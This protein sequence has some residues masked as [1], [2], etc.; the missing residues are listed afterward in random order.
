MADPFNL[1]A[2]FY[3]Q[4]IPQQVAQDQANQ[5]GITTNQLYALYA[6]NAAQQSGGA[7]GLNIAGLVA[8]YQSGPG[9]FLDQANTYRTMSSVL[10]G[11]NQGQQ[12]TPTQPGTI[13]L[14]GADNPAYNTSLIGAKALDA[15]GLGTGTMTINPTPGMTPMGSKSGVAPVSSPTT[16]DIRGMPMPQTSVPSIF[17]PSRMPG[18]PT[19]ATASKIPG[20]ISDIPAWQSWFGKNVGNTIMVNGMPRTLA[21]GSEQNPVSNAITPGPLYDAFS[22]GQASWTANTPAQYAQAK[23]P[24]EAL[25]VTPTI[26]ANAAQTQTPQPFATPPT[27]PTTLPPAAPTSAYPSQRQ[28]WLGDIM[29]SEPSTQEINRTA[30]NAANAT[31]GNWMQGPAPTG[32]GQTQNLGHLGPTNMQLNAG[33]GLINQ[34]GQ[35]GAPLQRYAQQG[36][37]P[38]L[39]SSIPSPDDYRQLRPIA[40]S[41]AQMGFPGT[42]GGFLPRAAP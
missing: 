35:A 9:S 3:Q 7:Q 12:N 40:L 33:L 31:V 32:P 14:S 4:Q 22:K 6:A 1:N 42:P 18:T 34:A 21:T 41:G 37:M 38:W 19:A 30:A 39:Q 8:P 28:G 2:A 26:P 5:L 24:T 13:Q 23:P 27:I 10:G 36:P 17:S 25:K 20:G 16:Y 29:R 11:P 15:L